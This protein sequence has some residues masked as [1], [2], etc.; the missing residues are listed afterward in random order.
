MK[1]ASAEIKYHRCLA[2]LMIFWLTLAGGCWKGVPMREINHISYQLI[3]GPILPELRQSEEYLVTHEGVTLTRAGL[4][5]GTQVQEG[6]WD[7]SAD[8]HALENLFDR[9]S[10]V[11]CAKLERV[12]PA[13]APDGGFTEII[14]LVYADGS[15]CELLLDPGV[16]YLH[17][18]ELLSA[19]KEFMQPYIS[20]D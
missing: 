1:R 15:K 16:T 2:V 17:S 7:Y 4:V 14:Q 3:S 10:G 12:E 13:H 6:Q 5:P 8:L 18:E 11:D 20:Q 19:V 9:L